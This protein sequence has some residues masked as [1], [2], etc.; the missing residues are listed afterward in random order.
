MFTKD[1]AAVESPDH[2]VDLMTSTGSRASSG[3]SL[4]LLSS[5]R[6]LF[7]FLTYYSCFG[8]GDLPWQTG[9]SLPRVNDGA[10]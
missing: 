10:K 2:K 9:M 1:Q 8:R 7:A 3:T 5:F 6:I 4:P